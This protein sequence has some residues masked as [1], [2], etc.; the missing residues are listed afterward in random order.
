M[1]KTGGLIISIITE[2]VT[3]E[4]IGNIEKEDFISIV[5]RLEKEFHSKQPGFIDSELLYDEK[6]NLWFIIQHWETAEQLNASSKKMFTDGT[7][8]AFVKSLNPK[9]VKMTILQ[10]LKVW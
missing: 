5:D 3:F 7:A 1:K 4:K 9:T 8:E 2:I 6:D 10:Q